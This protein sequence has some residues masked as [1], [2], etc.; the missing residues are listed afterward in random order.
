MTASEHIKQAVEMGVLA[1]VFGGLFVLYLATG[2]ATLYWNFSASRA[3]N[4][5]GYWAA[6]GLIG[7]ICLACLYAV[8]DSLSRL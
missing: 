8:V 3:S 1:L 5:A 4:P 6:Q 7:A 2:R